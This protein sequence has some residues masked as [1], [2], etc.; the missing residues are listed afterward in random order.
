MIISRSIH[1]AADVKPVFLTV[2]YFKQG[3]Y[4]L[5]CASPLPLHLYVEA[6]TPNVIV[7]EDTAFKEVI[8][9][10]EVVRVGP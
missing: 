8:R 6:L 10:C 2:L 7:F 5:N 9:V 1:V 4:G 3:C